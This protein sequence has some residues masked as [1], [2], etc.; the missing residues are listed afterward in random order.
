M[1]DART[2]VPE[3]A[4]PTAN[5]EVTSGLGATKPDRCS[6][7][8]NPFVFNY[9][10]RGERGEPCVGDP[11]AAARVAS[12]AP[13]ID[14]ADT[15]TTITYLLRCLRAHAPGARVL[16]NLRA[17]DAINAIVAQMNEIRS[18]RA[19]MLLAW[20]ACHEGDQNPAWVDVDVAAEFIRSTI[21]K[22]KG[23]Q[24]VLVAE[25]KAWRRFGL[26]CPADC[27]SSG[28][29]FDPNDH[30]SICC[31]CGCDILEH[32]RPDC[33]HDATTATDAAGALGGAS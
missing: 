13:E 33:M 32:R 26:I 7:C 29:S 9:C 8:G 21:D 1:E 16:G 30:E 25:V 2:Q 6:R 15:Q 24:A 14:N 22:L 11:E 28:G 4:S 23:D 18:L 20:G 27:E 10:P 31:G 12:P 5:I 3:S 19:A 17:W